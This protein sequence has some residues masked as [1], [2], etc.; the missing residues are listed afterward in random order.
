MSPINTQQ[1]FYENLAL[2]NAEFHLEFHRK[3]ESF[4]NKGWY[5]LGNEV[6]KFERKFAEYCETDYFVGLAS[7]LDALEIGLRTFDFPNNS[8]IIVS[9]NTYIATVLAIINAGLKPVLVEPNIKTYN[10]DK[11]LIEEKITSKTVA[12]LAVHLYGQMAE[13]EAINCIAEKYNLKIIEDCAQAHGATHKGKKAGNYSNI[14]AF[15][16][17]PTKNLGALGD[18]GGISLSDK[19]IYNKIKAIRNYG[20]HIK[21][22]NKYI[23]KNSRLD[24]LQAI[25]LNV[26]LCYLDKIN[27]HKQVLAENYNNLLTNNIIKPYKLPDNEHVYHIYNIRTIYRDELKKFLLKQNIH[28]E[29]HYPIPPNKQSAYVKYFKDEYYPISEEIHA[30]TLSLPISKSTTVQDVKLVADCINYFFEKEVYK[31]I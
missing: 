11:N 9:S 6:E 5:I 19:I 1:I 29:I 3:F 14:G 10:I 21:Y 22:K 16:F 25:F 26:K 17:Y 27:R 13:M 15:S 2:S 18:A 23:G 31:F 7:G 28:T 30:T 4:L 12:I 8:E 20:S 24:E